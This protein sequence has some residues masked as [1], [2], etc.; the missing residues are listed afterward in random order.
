MF[1]SESTR[2]EYGIDVHVTPTRKETTPA[3]VPVFRVI[4]PRKP[5]RR[6]EYVLGVLTIAAGLWAA[7]SFFRT[8]D[9]PAPTPEPVAVVAAAPVAPI[10]PAVAREATV[11]EDKPA[12]VAVQQIAPIVSDDPKAATPKPPKV[13]TDSGTN[14]TPK[15][16]V[17]E[18]AKR[19]ARL[20][21]MQ[22]EADAL[23]KEKVIADRNAKHADAERVEDDA[24]NKKG[25]LVWIAGAKAQASPEM[26][27]DLKEFRHT[28][29]DKQKVP[30][31]KYGARVFFIGNDGLEYF[32][33]APFK[34][35]TATKIK[36]KFGLVEASAKF[37]QVD[38]PLNYRNHNLPDGGG[39]CLWAAASTQ[40][41]VHGYVFRLEDNRRGGAMESDV[42]R[43]LKSY[44]IPSQWTPMSRNGNLSYLRDVCDAGLGCT[45][46]VCLGYQQT[47]MGPMPMLHE[48][49]L[50]G[51]NDR[52][53]A[54]LDNNDREL[55][56]RIVPIEKF[57]KL[58]DGASVTIFPKG[59]ETA[60]V[61]KWGKPRQD[62]MVNPH[63]RVGQDKANPRGPRELGGE[64]GRGGPV[65][66]GPGPDVPDDSE[67]GFYVQTDARDYFKAAGYTD[68]EIPAKMQGYYLKGAP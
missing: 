20:K 11:K 43:V 55:R 38:L 33:R 34:A 28:E 45:V 35:D 59:K 37:P 58:W 8:D 39:C 32:I 2:K 44:K 48:I 18:E 46:G 22:K 14:R 12:A 26:L 10:T 52:E 54:T 47:P 62:G 64:E 53:V 61:A 1:L 13:I 4:Q 17:A 29:I 42:W 5:S 27:N 3:N 67:I 50:V 7:S 49:N 56:V 51:I 25:E 6:R 30:E 63:A 16:D 24:A 23:L 66:P 31:D 60:L 21:E 65:A 36:S 57:K 40:A 41:Y 68:K 15:P 9:K 19:D